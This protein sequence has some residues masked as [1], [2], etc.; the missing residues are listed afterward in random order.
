MSSR[1]SKS[2][3][4][5]TVA[6]ERA[7]PRLPLLLH[8]SGASC[9][10]QHWSFQPHTA[11]LVLYHQQRLPSIADLQ[12]WS[13]RLRD[14]G[15]TRVRTTALATPAALRAESAGFHV[16]QELALLEHTQPRR[17]PPRTTSARTT[18]TA[19]RRLVHS[20]HTEASAVDVAAF[21]TDW[22]LEPRAIADVCAATPRHRAR[23]AGSPVAAYAITGRDAKQGF[24]QRLAVAPQH[25]RR[26]LGR[27]LVLD[28]L[29]WLARWRV[30]RV[31]VN[32]PTDNL[33]ALRL[34]EQ[35]GFRQLAE[36]LRVYE[37]VLS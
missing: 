36:S 28:S 26:G 37:Q 29:H 2:T 20:Q 1:S 25:Q 16:I 9:R 30:Q 6:D 12:R 3:P 8:G 4:H 32:T 10:V 19:T 18:A 17:T 24:L 11:Q 21:T 7:D 35:V 5:G 27:E 34:Y 33:A 13:D 31:L 23:V 22:A 15:Y 14:L